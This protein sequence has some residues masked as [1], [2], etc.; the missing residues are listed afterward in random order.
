[1][2]PTSCPSTLRELL[3]QEMKEFG[4]DLDGVYVQTWAGSQ[5]LALPLFGGP[6]EIWISDHDARLEEPL[7]SYTGLLAQLEP[8]GDGGDPD[9]SLE[10]YASTSTDA[11]ADVRRLLDVLAPLLTARWPWSPSGT[12]STR[13]RS[14]NDAVLGLY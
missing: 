5:T 4:F 3:L 12:R 6:A 11:V 10:L 13:T 2:A 1:M 9:L 14:G 7:E 8:Q